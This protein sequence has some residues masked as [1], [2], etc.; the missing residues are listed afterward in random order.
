MLAWRDDSM[1][2]TN[3]AFSVHLTAS[4]LSSFLI[5]ST[6]FPT[7]SLISQMKEFSLLLLFV[8]F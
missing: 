6:P 4:G 3:D 7:G 8:S 2:R 1:R 5:P